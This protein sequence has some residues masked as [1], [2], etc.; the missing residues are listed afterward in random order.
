MKAKQVWVLVPFSRPKFLQNVID[1][2]TRQTFHNKKLIIVENGP[3]L[4]ACKKANFNPDLLITCNEHHQSHA[5]NMALHELRGMGGGFWC[6]F[7]DDDYYGYNF[8][9]E[10]AEHSD[11]AEVIGKSDQFVRM[12]GGTLRSF[13]GL[14][15]NEHVHL[16][17]GP[18]ICSWAEGCCD[19]PV[20]ESK[21]G[22]DC[23]FLSEMQGTGAEIWATSKFNFV[24]NR[25]EDVEAHHTWKVQDRELT[26]S[27]SFGAGPFGTAIIKDYGVVDNYDFV[28]GVGPEPD[29]ELIHA[30]PLS[31]ERAEEASEAGVPF[32]D[33]VDASLT[34]MGFSKEGRQQSAKLR[35]HSSFKDGF[36]VTVVEEDGCTIEE[37]CLGGGGEPGE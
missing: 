25:Y 2:F 26:D 11:K 21:V 37:G 16:V 23:Q 18:T 32:K 19:Y 17:H 24:F 5:K 1:N 20:P 12:A 10:M 34:I 28:N 3:A 31:E 9:E 6:N 7:D 27:L 8:I 13:E 15:H 30:N 4:G 33:F 22:E 14:G 36:A 29:C 35:A